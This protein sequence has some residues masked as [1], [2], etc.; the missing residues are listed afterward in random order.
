[1][2]SCP[3][4][5]SDAGALYVICRVPSAAVVNSAGELVSAVPPTLAI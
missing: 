2:V 1:M 5:G 4:D 3:V